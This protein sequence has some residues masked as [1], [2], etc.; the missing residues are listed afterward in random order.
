MSSRV[1]TNAHQVNHCFCTVLWPIS[2]MVMN[3]MG[4][5]TRQRNPNPMITSMY[6][7]S[8]VIGLCHPFT[9]GDFFNSCVGIK[10]CI[11]QVM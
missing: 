2:S 7:S 4:D 5:Y 8:T 11:L 1:Q 9:Y 10:N 3:M 6:H